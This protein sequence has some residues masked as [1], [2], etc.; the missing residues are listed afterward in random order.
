MLNIIQ[1][2]SVSGLSVCYILYLRSSPIPNTCNT[3]LYSS[4]DGSYPARHIVGKPVSNLLALLFL[5][6]KVSASRV[7]PLKN[8]FYNLSIAEAPPRE[9]PTVP[10][11]ARN[12]FTVSQ[13]LTVSQSVSQ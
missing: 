6:A 13:V 5:L 8:R 11:G 4:N 1:I 10:R 9:W 7:P 2:L 3:L 12:Y